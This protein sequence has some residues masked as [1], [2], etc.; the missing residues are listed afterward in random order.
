V[1]ADQGGLERC[2]HALAAAE[3]GDAEAERRPEEGQPAR[4]RRG[5]LSGL[6]HDASL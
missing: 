6:L 2:L 3:G 5:G 1:I 4:G